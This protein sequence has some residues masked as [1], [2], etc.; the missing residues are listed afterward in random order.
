M[1]RVELLNDCFLNASK[2]A[3]VTFRDNDTAFRL[4]NGTVCDAYLKDDGI[5]LTCNGTQQFVNNLQLSIKFG[6]EKNICRSSSMHKPASRNQDGNITQNKQTQGWK[7]QKGT[8]RR[9]N[10]GSHH[11][12]ARRPSPAFEEDTPMKQWH[13]SASVCGFCGEDNHKE[14]RCKFGE[15]ISCHTC[16]GLRH[17]AK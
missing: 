11:P 8:R 6:Y 4:K 10:Y 2:E 17:K 14:D 7:Y 3:N 13:H 5:Q 1:E 16:G 12:E 15:P 9:Q